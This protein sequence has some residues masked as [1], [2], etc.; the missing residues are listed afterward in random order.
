MEMK[1]LSLKDLLSVRTLVSK[2][3]SEDTGN[4]SERKVRDLNVIKALFMFELLEN[5][6]LD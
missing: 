4:T 2:T 6:S 3:G 1:C 5:A